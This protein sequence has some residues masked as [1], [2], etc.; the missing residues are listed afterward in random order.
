[1]SKSARCTAVLCITQPSS[2][3]IKHQILQIFPPSRTRGQVREVPI[4]MEGD[5][6]SAVNRDSSSGGGLNRTTTEERII[7]TNAPHAEHFGKFPL[8][9]ATFGHPLCFRFPHQTG[10]TSPGPTG[11]PP[12]CEEAG[13]LV[14]RGLSSFFAS[15]TS[16]TL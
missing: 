8:N 1:M 16:L 11:Y 2:I 5:Q 9:F 12:I 13:I 3:V 4:R 10:Q 15:I 14:T 6:S 7:P